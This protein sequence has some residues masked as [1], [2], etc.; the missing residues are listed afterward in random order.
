MSATGLVLGDDGVA[1]CSWGASAP[2]YLSYHDQEWGRRVTGDDRLYERLTL[3]A[4]QSGLSWLTI[5]RKREGFRYA[6]ADFSIAAVAAFGPTSN[7]SWP[8]PPSSATGPRSPR[9]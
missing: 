7:A 1:R 2:D 5:L 6:F 8:T 3:E 4:F 9:P